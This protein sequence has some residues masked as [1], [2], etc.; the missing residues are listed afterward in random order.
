MNR[1]VDQRLVTR[2]IVVMLV[3]ASAACAPGGARSTPPALVAFPGTPTA[4]CVREEVLPKIE[5]LQP[6][7]PRPGSEV[8]VS[9]QG[10]YFRDNCGGFIEGARTYKIYF[11]DEPV[12]ELLC[13]VGDCQTKFVLPENIEPGTHCMGVQKGTCQIEVSVAGE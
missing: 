9:A 10:G 5:K 1:S 13:Y 11:D 3:L 12:A 8:T 6:A 4:Q 2:F 7:E